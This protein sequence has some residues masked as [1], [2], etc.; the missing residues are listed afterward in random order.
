VLQSQLDKMIQMQI[1]NITIDSEPPV[2][3]S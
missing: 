3:E 2:P 1:A